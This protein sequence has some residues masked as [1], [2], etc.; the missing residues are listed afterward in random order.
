VRGFRGGNETWSKGLPAKL[1]RRDLRGKVWPT[2]LGGCL[3]INPNQETEQRGEKDF[4]ALGRYPDNQGS[5]RGT[6]EKAV[7]Y[8]IYGN[9]QRIEK[10]LLWSKSYIPSIKSKK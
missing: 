3:I 7:L 8:Y 10:K 2:I 1:K 9:A 4:K 5:T 6:G